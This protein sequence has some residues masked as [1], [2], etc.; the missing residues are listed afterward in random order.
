MEQYIKEKY[1]EYNTKEI[2]SGYRCKTYLLSKENKKLIYQVYFGN[3][4]YQAKKK[5]YITELI[6]SNKEIPQI[7]TIY[8][9]YEDTEYSHLV[10]EYKDGIELDQLQ[11]ISFDYKTFYNQL[12]IILSEIHSIN[13][14]NKFRLDRSKWIRR[15]RFFL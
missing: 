9:Y 3:T 8:E 10:S 11:D 14:G 1:K 4:K 13:I 15:K 12:S 2:Q 7:P 5:K 6:K